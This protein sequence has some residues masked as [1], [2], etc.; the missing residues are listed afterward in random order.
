MQQEHHNHWNLVSLIHKLKIQ[1]G[2]VNLFNTFNNR[3]KFSWFLIQSFHC[4]NFEYSTQGRMGHF[5][6][7]FASFL[8]LEIFIPCLVSQH[9]NIVKYISASHTGL[10][11][12]EGE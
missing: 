4:D 1:A 10:E 8:K 12:H 11:Q 6:G 9:K 2:F 5:Y 3:L 7:A